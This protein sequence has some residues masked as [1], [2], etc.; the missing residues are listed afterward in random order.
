MRFENEAKA[1]HERVMAGYR[2]IAGRERERVVTVDGNRPVSEI[3][4]EVE[5]I[6]FDRTDL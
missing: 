2:E 5:S 4:K 3:Q 6:F 1:F